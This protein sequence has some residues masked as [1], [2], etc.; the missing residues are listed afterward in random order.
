MAV[1]VLQ[2]FTR[3]RGP[4]GRA[5]HEEAFATGVGEGPD[6]IAYALESEHR[7]IGE[8]GNRLQTVVRMSGSGGGEG[9]HRTRLGNTLLQNL[10]VLSLAIVEDHVLV[11]RL[12]ELSLAGVDADLPD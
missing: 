4:A 1:L 2:S 7:V 8:E 6:H 3:Q 10:A 11:V 5:S 9:R 12:V